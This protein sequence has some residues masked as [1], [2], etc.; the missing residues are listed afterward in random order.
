[1]ERPVVLKLEFAEPV[2]ASEFVDRSARRLR[3]ETRLG[4]GGRQS[5]KLACAGALDGRGRPA[6]G[7]PVSADDGRLFRLVIVD[8]HDPQSPVMPRNVQIAEIEL[9]DDEQIVFGGRRR[10]HGSTTIAENVRR[11]SGPVHGDQTPNICSSVRRRA[12]RTGDSLGRRDDVSARRRRRPAR[13]AGTGRKLEDP[14]AWLHAGRFACFDFQRRLEGLGDRLLDPAAFEQYW[15][16]VVQPL[17]DAARPYV[18]KSLKFL[19]TDSW[20]LGP[21]NWTP[22]CRRSLRERA[23][24]RDGPLT[25]PRWPATWSMTARRRTGFST[26]FA[27]RWAI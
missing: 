22:R 12:E 23:R 13:V 16:D 7:D 2:T 25:C 4:A 17:M 19:H 1:M 27:A 11:L 24:L 15:Q 5:A 10:W 3:A 14:A 26:I 9:R 18:G 21:I 6:N 8:S 20:E